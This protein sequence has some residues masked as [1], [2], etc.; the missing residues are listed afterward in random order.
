MKN[1]TFLSLICFLLLNSSIYCA[2]KHRSLSV[3]SG[4]DD[5]DKS[6]YS[7][8]CLMLD[9]LNRNLSLAKSPSLLSASFNSLRDGLT[10]TER[11]VYVFEPENGRIH[12]YHSILRQ[13]F[14][15]KKIKDADILKSHCDSLFKSFLEV[16][17]GFRC[18]EDGVSVDVVKKGLAVPTLGFEYCNLLHLAIYFFQDICVI[19]RLIKFGSD[20]NSTCLLT[21]DGRD[22]FFS[23]LDLAIFLNNEEVARVLS[24]M[25]AVY[26]FDNAVKLEIILKNKREKPNSKKE[27]CLLA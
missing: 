23:P 26:D 4:M 5:G 7:G 18:L 6:S 16:D 24:E 27:C 21:V 11:I 9:D 15:I 19:N 14:E 25:D 10:P 3:V 17:S 2:S 22:Q 8:G 13:L 20:I 12:K 1:D